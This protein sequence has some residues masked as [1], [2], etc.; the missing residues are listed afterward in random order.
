MP[1]NEQSETVYESIL[2]TIEHKGKLLT[3]WIDIHE[4]IYDTNHETPKAE[5]LTIT[6]SNSHLL[7]CDCFYFAS[8]TDMYGTTSNQN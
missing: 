2:V 4:L 1:Q 5:A 3:K 7:L 8:A 6:L